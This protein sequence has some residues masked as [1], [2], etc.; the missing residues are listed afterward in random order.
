[1]QFLTYPHAGERWLE[2]RLSRYAAAS[3]TR[4]LAQSLEISL[5]N[6]AS[7]ADKGLGAGERPTIRIVRN[8]LSVLASFCNAELCHAPLET[9]RKEFFEQNIGAWLN[10]KSPCSTELLQCR[11]GLEAMI[12]ASM[13]E[14]AADHQIHIRI[15][16]FASFPSATLR[17]ICVFFEMNCPIELIRS[18]V[19]ADKPER[20]KSRF[21]RSFDQRSDVVVP[22]AAASQPTQHVQIQEKLDLFSWVDHVPGA[23]A[24]AVIGQYESFFAAYYPEVHGLFSANEPA[25]RAA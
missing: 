9:S 13:R 2:S 22:L 1:M 7:C 18:F 10:S 21:A 15:E 16:D 23:L 17:R 6:D 3:A 14:N 24:Q 20:R 12:A 11:K 5:I 4:E 25:R 19:N 8:P